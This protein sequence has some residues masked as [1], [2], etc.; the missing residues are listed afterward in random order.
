M[1]SEYEDHLS[2]FHDR[3]KQQMGITHNELARLREL[4]D[5]Q[6]T[7]MDKAQNALSNAICPW[8]SGRHV[9]V[10]G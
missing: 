3:E 5:E 8:M 2:R 1:L 6:R 7:E 10:A 9:E 4:R